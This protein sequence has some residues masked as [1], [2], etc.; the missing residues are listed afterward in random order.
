[1][2]G[3]RRRSAAATAT[4]LLAVGVLP[5]VSHAAAA[6]SP[7]SQRATAVPQP[8]SAK[9]PT[10]SPVT[11]HRVTKRPVKVSATTLR[12]ITRAITTSEETSLVPANAYR[13]R[14]VRLAGADW[15]RA[16]LVPS[17]T[18][19]L[20]PATVVLHRTGRPARWQVADLGTDGVGCDIAPPS[21]LRSLRL[22]CQ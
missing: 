21:V 20:D 6:P 4:V 18:A 3:L 12:S 9:R 2:S 7:T 8:V 10:S 1:M 15:A 11:P 5:G 17:S 22:S 13:V 14:G 19:E 16:T